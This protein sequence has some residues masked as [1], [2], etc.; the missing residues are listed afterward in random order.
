[1]SPRRASDFF[2]RDKKVTKKARLPTAIRRNSLR[3][4]SSAQTAAGSMKGF[5]E[6]KDRDGG[7]TKL[8]LDDSPEA[9]GHAHILGAGVIG[10]HAGRMIDS[11]ALPRWAKASA[12]LLK[13][14]MAL[15]RK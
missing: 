11:P 8:L 9:C 12:W 13:W 6:S 5:H 2:V 3:A 1:M 10:T 4:C 15:A 14:R 7:F